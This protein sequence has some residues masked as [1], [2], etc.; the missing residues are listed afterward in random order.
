M[1]YAFFCSLTAAVLWSYGAGA[2]IKFPDTIRLSGST[3]INEKIT[4]A[5]SGI[6][7]MNLKDRHLIRFGATPVS[8]NGRCWY[9]H[10]S[11]Q[12]LTQMVG[13]GGEIVI[14][15]SGQNIGVLKWNDRTSTLSVYSIFADLSP[16]EPYLVFQ[17]RA[18]SK[19]MRP[20]YQLKV[21]AYDNGGKKVGTYESKTPDP[22]REY[23]KHRPKGNLSLSSPAPLKQD[24]RGRRIVATA[25]G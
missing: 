16:T 15:K 21:T 3:F 25:C 18:S 7:G 13:G 4:V 12:R 17:E 5:Q 2:C 23:S 9:N 11:R 19:S 22:L 1:F 14:T 10:N 20:S 6:K 24:L 8:H